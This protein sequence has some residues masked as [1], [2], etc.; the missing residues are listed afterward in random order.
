MQIQQTF[1]E[2]RMASAGDDMNG[3]RWWKVKPVTIRKVRRL[4]SRF[5]VAGI[6]HGTSE[7][8][9]AVAGYHPA[10]FSRATDC[11]GLH[12]FW[13]FEGLLSIGNARLHVTSTN[14]NDPIALKLVQISKRCLFSA[15]PG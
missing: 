14:F 10:T 4:F 12:D 15:W 9:L 7:I 2:P 1:R 3:F 11:L 5:M 13:M 6:E 8:A